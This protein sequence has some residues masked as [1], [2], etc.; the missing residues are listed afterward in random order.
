MRRRDEICSNC[1]WLGPV[2]SDHNG[3]SLPT[4]RRHAPLAT[5]GLHTAFETLW[6]FVDLNDWCGDFEQPPVEF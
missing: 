6:P 4:C 2:R 3:D 5:G 1:R